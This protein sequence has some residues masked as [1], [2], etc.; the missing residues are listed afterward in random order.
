MKTLV[1]YTVNISLSITSYHAG[2]T[3]TLGHCGDRYSLATKRGKTKPGESY[4]FENKV[5]SSAKLVAK[6]RLG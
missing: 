2:M 1:Y 5:Q 6:W 3:A 4:K